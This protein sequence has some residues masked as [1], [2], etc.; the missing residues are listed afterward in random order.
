MYLYKIE[1]SFNFVFTDDKKGHT[2]YG[3]RE[4]HVLGN[5]NGVEDVIQKTKAYLWKTIDGAEKEDDVVI[6][7]TKIHYVEYL[8]YVSF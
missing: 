4:F 8:N 1:I 6:T 5:D 2:E 7:K 3:N